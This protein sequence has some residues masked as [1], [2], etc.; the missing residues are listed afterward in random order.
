MQGS[1]R[2]LHG[3]R[4]H[5]INGGGMLLDW[6]IHLLDQIMD[7]V[8]SQVV[9]VYAHVLSI[10]NPEVDDNIKIFLLF[11]NNVS[12]LVEVSTNCFINLPRWHVSCSEGTAIIEDWVCN[13][14]MVKLNT[15]SQMEWDDE[16]I[17]TEAGP[18]RT[19]APRP[20]HTTENLKL[21]EITTDWSDYY[22]NIALAIDG[23]ADLIV[24][25]EQALRVMNVVDKIFES[26][27]AGHSISCE[28]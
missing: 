15:D 1:R 22:N 21:P 3:W 17:Y 9:S 4:G 19:M 11:K 24:K 12:A 2:S 26:G 25:P 13:G 16:I 27:K 20:V 23:K 6:G 28:I 14:K 5:K 18:T 7:L 8:D 10:F